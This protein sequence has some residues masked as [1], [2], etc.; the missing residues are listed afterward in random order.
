MKWSGFGV[1][2]IITCADPRKV[3]SNFAGKRWEDL[4]ANCPDGVD[5]CGE[6]GEFHTFTIACPAFRSPIPVMVRGLVERD[7]FVFADVDSH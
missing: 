5:P 2:A 4:V 7:G 6:Y 3:P 1:S